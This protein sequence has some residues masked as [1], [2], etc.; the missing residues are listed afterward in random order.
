VLLLVTGIFM[1]PIIAPAAAVLIAGA[2]LT[3]LY[4]RQWSRL[5]ELCIGFLPV[6][7]MAL[8]DQAAQ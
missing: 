2:G 3:A 4:Q 5:A 8:Q 7:S 6:F 1:K